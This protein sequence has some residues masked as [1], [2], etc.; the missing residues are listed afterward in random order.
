MLATPANFDPGVAPCACLIV[1]RLEINFRV[2]KDNSVFYLQVFSCISRN[3]AHHLLTH[4]N[5]VLCAILFAVQN[6]LNIN[7]TGKSIT[8]VLI[9]SSFKIFSISKSYCMHISCLYVYDLQFMKLHGQWKREL[10]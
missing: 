4:T 5:F 6:Y 10:F 7:A 3:S 9:S 2:V 8:A 1:Q